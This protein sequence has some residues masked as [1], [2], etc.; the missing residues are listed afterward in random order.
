[1]VKSYKSDAFSA[2]HATISDLQNAGVVSKRTLK[3]FDDR[4]LTAVHRFSATQIKHLR[5]NENVSQ[6]VFAHYLNVSPD[7]V[8]KWEQ[9]IK[10]PAGPSLKLLSL[11]EKNG[12]N[13]IS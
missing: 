6:A 4:C 7:A 12:L 2:I 5:Q 3:E 9:G 1:M 10:H 13:Y 11:V 8:R